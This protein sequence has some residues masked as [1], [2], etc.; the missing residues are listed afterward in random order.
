MACR[1]QL[2]DRSPMPS[3]CSFPAPHEGFQGLRTNRA[4]AGNFLPQPVPASLSQLFETVSTVLSRSWELHS[5]APVAHHQVCI[6]RPLPRCPRCSSITTIGT[7][8]SRGA[9][10]VG[11]A[12]A[13]FACA[14]RRGQQGAASGTLWSTRQPTQRP[15]T[16]ARNGSGTVEM[17]SE[18]G[19]LANQSIAHHS[20]SSH[21]SSL[22][23]LA[24]HSQDAWSRTRTASSR[25]DRQSASTAAQP[26][27]MAPP[28]QRHNTPDARTTGG[29]HGTIGISCP[30]STYSSPSPSH[31]QCC[32]LLPRPAAQRVPL[33][34]RMAG[35]LGI[36]PAR[37]RLPTRP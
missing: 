15:P 34:P 9:Q 11:S 32:V 19:C 30:A 21:R 27:V 31:L 36:M 16:R 28:T 8:C 33:G 29:I 26:I 10:S 7:A 1:F 18:L 17:H 5:T 23:H 2:A 6:Y 25:V 4:A 14:T 22:A 20:L 24:H 35:S 12:P 3:P 37:R 13:P